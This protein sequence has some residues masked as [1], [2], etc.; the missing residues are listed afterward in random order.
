MMPVSLTLLAACAPPPAKTPD[1][2]ATPAT[3]A[4]PE[5]PAAGAQPDSNATSGGS[6]RSRLTETLY[7]QAAAAKEEVKEGAKEAAQDENEVNAIETGE[8]PAEVT[9]TIGDRAPA[10]SIAGWALGNEVGKFKK[11]GVYVVEFWATWCPPCRMSMPHLSKLQKEYGERVQ[12]I[13]VTDEDE[14]TVTKFL[15]E[16]MD[17]ESEQTW[18]ETISYSLALDKEKSTASAYM[19]A[20]GQGG[21]PTAFIV[22]KDGLIEWIGHPM[23]MDEPLRQVADGSWNRGEFAAT[24]RKKQEAEK[25][26]MGLQLAVQQRDWDKALEVTETLS[27]SDP[28]NPQWPMVRARIQMMSG[29]FKDANAT[30]DAVAKANWENPQLLNFAAWTMMTEVPEEERN[31]KAAQGI[32]LR[33]QE[34]TQGKDGSVLDSLALSYYLQGDLEKAIET[35]EKAV[36][37]GSQGNDEALRESLKRYQ[38]ELEEKKNGGKAAKDKKDG[39]KEGSEKADDDQ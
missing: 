8:A 37:V 10:V 20:S 3:P 11:G 17:S 30:F 34:L 31:I 32:I 15:D 23:E 29:R 18:R 13:G 14:E 7:T 12:F 9:L 24:F 22:G 21:I 39:D 4:A 27:A 1:A 16:R 28:K 26:M 5:A 6:L 19:A 33:A 25:M 36:E 35:Q 2:P 38:T